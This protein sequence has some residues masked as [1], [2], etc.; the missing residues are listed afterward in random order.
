MRRARR[1]LTGGH[2]PHER[3]RARVLGATRARALASLLTLLLPDSPSG[4]GASTLSTIDCSVRSLRTSSAGLP[5]RSLL[6]VGQCCESRKWSLMHVLQNVCRH[7]MIV[8]ASRKYPMQSVHARYGLSR[9]VW[10]VIVAPSRVGGGQSADM[11]A[12]TS[13]GFGSWR[14]GLSTIAPLL[15]R[16]C[17]MKAIRSNAPYSTSGSSIDSL[18]DSVNSRMSWIFLAMECSG[19]MQLAFASPAC[20]RIWSAIALQSGKYACP[21]VMC[22]ETRTVGNCPQGKTSESKFAMSWASARQR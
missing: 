2:A 6:H 4:S 1:G 13:S 19:R 22:D 14:G 18:H 3:A 7:S 9:R 17:S 11:R 5:P 21:S 8:H 15:V 16:G 12:L 10:N 20:S